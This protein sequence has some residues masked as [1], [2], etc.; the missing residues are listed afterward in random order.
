MGIAEEYGPGCRRYICV[1]PLL[2]IDGDVIEIKMLNAIDKGVCVR[3]SL[4]VCAL[5]KFNKSIGKERPRGVRC[6]RQVI[7]PKSRANHR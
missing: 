6:L 5:K 7:S 2:R 1:Q 3:V 4:G